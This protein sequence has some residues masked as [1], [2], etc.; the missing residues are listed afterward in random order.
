MPGTAPPEVSKALATGG[1]PPSGLSAEE[2]RA[3]EQLEFLFTKGIGYATEM[4]LRPQTLYGLADSPVALAAWMLD[5]DAQSYEDIAR[6][7]AGD[8]VGDL[9]RDEVLDNVTLSWVTNTG[10]LLGASLLGEHARVLRLQGRHGSGRGERVPSTSS[11]RRRGAGPSR[12]TPTSSTSTKSTRATTSRP[13]RSRSF[14]HGGA[15]GVSVTAVIGTPTSL[16]HVV[17]ACPPD[18]RRAAE[19]RLRRRRPGRRPC[20]APAARLAVRHPQLR[21][22][23]AAADRGGL[24]GDRSVPARLRDDALP[25]RRDASA[26]ASR[27]R[28]LWTRSRCMDALGIE[29]R[30]RRRLR[31]GSAHRRHRRGALAGA[32]QRTGLGERLSDRQPGSRHG[33]AAAGGRAAVVVPVLLRHRARPGRLRQVPRA[34][35]RS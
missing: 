5:H 2:S 4:N 33:A 8:P 12:P 15:R 13:G 31:L 18:R 23:R 24:P 14:H 9:T 7:F 26:T 1:P 21:R 3:W 35:S 27:R 11:I 28:W 10:D 32:L 16:E 17:R 20:G 30:D 19:R 29:T 34:S 6:A 22:R 25:L